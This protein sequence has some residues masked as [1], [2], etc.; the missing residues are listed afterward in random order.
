MVAA[1]VRA[2]REQRRAESYES[3]VPQKV[4]HERGL[5]ESSPAKKDRAWTSFLHPRDLAKST[6]VSLDPWLYVAALVALAVAAPLALVAPTRGKPAPLVS[7]RPVTDGDGLA[8]FSGSLG[9]AGA[10]RLVVRSATRMTFT[11]QVSYPRASK[12]A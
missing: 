11:L 2:G 1:G 8:M 7:F 9:S 6:R 4:V 12:G 5:L 3:S 10:L